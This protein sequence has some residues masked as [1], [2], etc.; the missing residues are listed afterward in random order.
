MYPPV[1]MLRL[2]QADVMD[3]AGRGATRYEVLRSVL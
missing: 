2:E 1:C 3:K